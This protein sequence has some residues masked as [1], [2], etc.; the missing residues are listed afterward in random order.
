MHNH[1]L[2]NLSNC[3][4]VFADA[5]TVLTKSYILVII[6]TMFNRLVIFLETLNHSN[7]LAKN[8]KAFSYEK[9]P[10]DTFCHK[11]LL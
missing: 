3:L 11:P 9:K 7:L 10:N 4:L 6:E 1:E 8:T 5:V 2:L